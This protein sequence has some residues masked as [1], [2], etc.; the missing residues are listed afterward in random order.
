MEGTCGHVENMRVCEDCLLKHLHEL[1]TT[2]KD[3][4]S[5]KYFINY[6]WDYL[7]TT[8]GCY[9]GSAEDQYQQYLKELKRVAKV[10]YINGNISPR[11]N[12]LPFTAE[13]INKVLTWAEKW[14]N[15]DKYKEWFYWVE[16]GK[17]PDDPK[18]HLHYIWTKNK[19]LDTKNHMRAMKADWNG[20]FTSQS[21][22]VNKDD[23]DSE[24]F[25]QEYLNDKLIYAINSCKD[26][27]EN[28][29]DL[30]SDPL[31]AQ[32]RAFGGS[33]SLTTKFENLIENQ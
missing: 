3:R 23:V 33:N 13:N 1:D 2:L 5:F 8:K 17:E 11:T 32:M 22:I 31:P 7:R 16:S 25:T 28:F 29:R 30:I 20:T 15:E 10:R 27:H 26:D 18:I 24:P 4:T 9:S 19:Y 12:K 6:H 21:K 14:F